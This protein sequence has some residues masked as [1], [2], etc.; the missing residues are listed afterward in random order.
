MA[1]QD[2]VPQV[3]PGWV[4]GLAAG[5]PKPP[6]GEKPMPPAPPG[7]IFVLADEG[8]Y[9]VP[10][11]RFELFFGR[12]TPNVHVPIGIGD[13]RVSRRQGVLT[14]QGSEWWMRNEGKLPIQLPGDALLL[15]GQEMPVPDGYL[16]LFI[17]DPASRTHLLE[18]RVISAKRLDPAVEP[19]SPTAIPQT[20]E[21]S[22]A[23]RLVL[24]ALA[25]R[26]LHG[27]RH[28]QPATWKEV[29]DT[30]NRLPSG[31]KW[32]EKTVANTVAP[33][34][35]RLAITRD[36]LPEPLG[37]ALNHKLIQVLLRNATLTPS[38]LE[39]LGDADD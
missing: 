2:F 38:D 27:Q 30:L 14:C 16:P 7:T 18:V 1:V 9:A 21:L 29:A 10:P 36:D 22:E 26:Y 11:R 17:G 6:P 8:G 33:V 25:K 39:Q 19:D 20:D 35:R 4:R 13:S 37:N 15:S 31:K 28:A 23:E 3:L 24:T 5:V 32:T 34:R 12:G